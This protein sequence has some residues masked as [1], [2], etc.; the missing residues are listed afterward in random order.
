MTETLEAEPQAAEQPKRRIANELRRMA[1]W[2]DAHP[3]AADELMGARAWSGN[4]LPEIKFFKLAP[5]AAAFPGRTCNKSRFEHSD[6]YR[7]TADGIAFE[8]WESVQR[9]WPIETEVIL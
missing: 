1:D 2:L 3:E 5:L 4:K 9:E 7:L 8:A 6:V